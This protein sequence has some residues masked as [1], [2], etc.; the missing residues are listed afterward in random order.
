VAAFEAAACDELI[1]FPCN[2]DVAQGDL[3][4]EAVTT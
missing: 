2:A 4:A 3:V 1:L